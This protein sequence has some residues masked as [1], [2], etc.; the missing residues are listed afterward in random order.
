MSFSAGNSSENSSENE[1]T[2][3]LLTKKKKRVPAVDCSSWSS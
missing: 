1:A 2:H 3:P